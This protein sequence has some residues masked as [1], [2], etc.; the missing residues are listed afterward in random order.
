MANLPKPEPTCPR[1]QSSS[2]AL[3]K[4]IREKPFVRQVL[5]YVE[6]KDC[7][8]ESERKLA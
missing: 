5:T 3:R 6:C 2:L 8:W 1:C 7:K 4:E